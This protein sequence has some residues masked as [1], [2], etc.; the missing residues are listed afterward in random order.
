MFFYAGA[1][2]D[3]S[4][5]ATWLQEQA[6]QLFQET[7][8]TKKNAIE[9][10]D[11]WAV[12]AVAMYFESMSEYDRHVTFGGFE[13]RRLQ[14]A[15]IRI[16]RQGFYVPLQQLVQLGREK[17]QTSENVRSLYSQ[18]AG[19][20]HFFMSAKNGKY[21]DAFLDYIKLV[22][23]NRSQPDS[24][25]TLIGQPF[26]KLDSEYK[27]FLLVDPAELKTMSQAELRTEIA[28]G[29]SPVNSNDIKPLAD[30]K[31]LVWLQLSG[32]KIDD[33]SANTVAELKSLTQLFVD[34]TTIGDDFIN[35]IGDL[36]NLEELDL[37][38]TQITDAALTQIAKLKKL[39]VLWL[40]RTQITDAGLEKLAALKSLEHLD[41]GG[42]RVTPLGLANLKSKLPQLK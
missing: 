37:A 19:L 41:V 15:R 20:A 16:N 2:N 29:A 38:G 7:G 17:Y 3:P 24:I 10:G 6:H 14:F 21:R 39:K 36:Q 27:A 8:V 35:G 5:R 12:E 1:E 22:Y 31:R 42:T 30:C 40:T 11:V 26:E 32:T 28:L 25:S 18:S 9:D 33:S 23:Q 13:A 4:I 34:G